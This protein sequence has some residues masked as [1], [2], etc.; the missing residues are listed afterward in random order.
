MRYAVAGTQKRVPYTKGHAH[1]D[2]AQSHQMETP[3]TKL[4]FAKEDG[5]VVGLGREEGL[6]D[7][8]AEKLDERAEY[9]LVM[10]EVCEP[11]HCHFKNLRFVVSVTEC[12]GCVCGTV[13]EACARWLALALLLTG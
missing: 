9:I 3:W 7:L 4:D 12:C 13:S 10:R 8:A 2:G 6:K 1:T 11:L 5:S